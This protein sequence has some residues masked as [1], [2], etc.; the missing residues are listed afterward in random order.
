MR[1]GSPAFDVGLAV[2]RPELDHR[3]RSRV[4]AHVEEN[5]ALPVMNIKAH[6]LRSVIGDR[7]AQYL[8]GNWRVEA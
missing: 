8:E 3:G 7:V 4:R 2:H 6:I 1:C 5:G